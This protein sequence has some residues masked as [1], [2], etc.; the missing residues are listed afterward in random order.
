MPFKKKTRE[1]W[2]EVGEHKCQ[3]V[4]YS[5]TKGFEI[6]GARAEHVHHIKP[7]SRLLA[8]GEDP[9]HTVGLPLCQNHHVRNFGREP[10]D[11]TSSFHPEMAY[12][13]KNYGDWKQHALH[14]ASITGRRSVNYKTS[15][16]AGVAKDYKRKSEAGDRICTGDEATDRFYTQHMEELATKARLE[17]GVVPPR[18]TPHKDY[19]PKKKKHWYDKLF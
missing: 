19:N 1:Y 7:Q 5:E 8:T 17:R 18:T 2:M 13:F 15:P 9:E 6:C 12:A 3:W 10:F 11:R 4:N 14:I 16:I